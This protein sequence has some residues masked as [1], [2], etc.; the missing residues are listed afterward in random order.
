[1]VQQ[2]NLANSGD[3]PRGGS[4]QSRT[5]VVWPCGVMGWRSGRSGADP[6]VCLLFPVGK[7][8]DL[9]ALDR[10]SAGGRLRIQKRIGFRADFNQQLSDRI[11]P[12]A[13]AGGDL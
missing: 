8:G 12:R 11:F 10:L 1:M 13:G 7:K 5:V 6:G 9:L 4:S 2:G 3:G